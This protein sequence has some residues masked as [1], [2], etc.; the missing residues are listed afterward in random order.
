LKS[1]PLCGRFHESHHLFDSLEYRLLVSLIHDRRPV[2]RIDIEELRRQPFGQRLELPDI[3]E[4]KP[5]IVK[6]GK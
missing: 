5:S 3:L 1:Y 2:V 4:R 6:Q